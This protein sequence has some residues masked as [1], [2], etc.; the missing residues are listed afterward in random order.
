[1]TPTTRPK[2]LLVDDEP[3]MLD[4]L[5]RVFRARYDVRRATSAEEGLRTLAEQDVRVLVTDQKMPR[6]TG[7]ELL[8]RVTPL[9]PGLVR[10]LLSGYTEMPDVQRA[11]ARCQLDGHVLKPVDSERLLEAVAEA[12]AT[13][14]G[15]GAAQ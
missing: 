1:M 7:L 12:V 3:D 5:E 9:Y 14:A 13:H 2:L 8:E 11:L 6:M 15:R 10:V 4:F